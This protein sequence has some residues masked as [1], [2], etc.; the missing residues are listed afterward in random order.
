MYIVQA[1]S[2]ILQLSKASTLKHEFLNFFIFSWV[3]FALRNPDL[4]DQIIS[5]P[6]PQNVF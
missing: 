2:R 5:D 3:I 4:A 1:S 6:D